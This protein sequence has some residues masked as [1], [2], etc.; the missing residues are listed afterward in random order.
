MPSSNTHIHRRGARLAAAASVLVA[1]IALA[2]VSGP[3]SGAQTAELDAVR[4][5]QDDVRASL[6]EQNAAVDSLL[7]EI[8]ELSE[9]EDAVAAELAEQEAKLAAARSE[10]AAARDQLA[11]TKEQL[12][13][14]LGDLRRLL[15]SVYRYGEIDEASVLLNSSGVDELANT[16]TYLDRIQDY[17]SGVV[18]RVRELREATEDQVA[19]IEDSVARIEAARLEIAKRRDALAAS[20]ASLEQR[21]AELEATQQDRREQLERLNGKEKGLLEALATPDHAPTDGDPAV[22]AAASAPADVSPGSTATLN[23]D[24]TAT[25][26]ANAPEAVKGAIAAANAITNAPYMYGGGHGSFE[27][28]GY[29]CSGSVSYALHGGGLLSAPLDS[30]GF[31]TWGDSGPGQWITVYSNPGHAYAVIAG[32]RFDTSGA[33]PRWQTAPATRPATSRRTRR[34]Y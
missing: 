10:L 33:P 13:R 24:G 19:T 27:S 28:A 3:T 15:V 7:G 18:D 30:T 5:E 14:S 8:A 25:A 21:Q 17:E 29:D 20:R 26:P 23:S 32:L 6:D 31:M 9:R 1:L 12:Q 2:L 11:E 22:P 16:S 4:A 34:A